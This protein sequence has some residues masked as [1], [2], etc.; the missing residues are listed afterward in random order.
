MIAELMLANQAFQ[1]IKEAVQNSGEIMSAGKAVMDWFTAKNELQKKIEEKPESERNDLEEFFALEEM[2]Q[3]EQELKDL[4]IIQG[5]P[6]LWEDWLKFQVQARHKREAAK[7]AVIRKQLEEEADKEHFIQQCLL[8][9]WI[10][11]LMLFLAALFTGAIWYI[12]T[13]G[14]F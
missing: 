8:W 1:V 7:A 13:K 5:R 14:K 4:M 12:I 11:V 9:F 10:S 3:K 2:K 6:G